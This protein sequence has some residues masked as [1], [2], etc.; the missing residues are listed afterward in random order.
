MLVRLML[1]VL[2]PITMV[3]VFSTEMHEGALK[4]VQTITYKNGQVSKR[5]FDKPQD[6]VPME[7]IWLD[8]PAA[9][10]NK[11]DVIEH[12]E[13]ELYRHHYGIQ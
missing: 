5:I 6:S 1:T 12:R 7:V 10:I 8:K 4:K 13:V 2:N 9:V 3:S 11:A